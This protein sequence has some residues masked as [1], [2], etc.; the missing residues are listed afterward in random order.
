M[1]NYLDKLKELTED[2]P[3]IPKLS[4]LV[5]VDNSAKHSTIY[6]VDK[7]TSFGISLLS[8][9]E[10]AVQ[11]LFVSKG[12]TFPEHVHEDEMEWG[13]I[14]KGEML[15][16]ID[17]KEE[18][19]KAGDCIAFNKGSIHSSLAIEDS[20]LIAIAIPKIDGYPE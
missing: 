6:K 7:G 10:V 4:D 18:S 15:V 8:R 13:I 9:A 14:Y 16:N 1:S 3:A 12:T 5:D 11:E 19:F 17:G 20:W 2:L